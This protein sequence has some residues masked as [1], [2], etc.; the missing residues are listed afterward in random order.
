M[1]QR[2]RNQQQAKAKGRR[3]RARAPP[4]TPLSLGDKLAY[5]DIEGD[6]DCQG[7]PQLLKNF[8][9]GQS[10]ECFE[11]LTLLL[12]YANLKEIPM[13]PVFLSKFIT[14]VTSFYSH[15]LCLIYIYTFIQ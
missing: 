12:G 3:A 5:A 13:W 10:S 2:R 9:K 15:I 6:E 14:L 4:T 11:V 7:L 1:S 8:K